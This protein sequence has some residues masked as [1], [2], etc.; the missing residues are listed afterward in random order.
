MVI[1]PRQKAAPEQQMIAKA[2][3]PAS[4]EGSP[5]PAGSAVRHLPTITLWHAGLPCHPSGPLLS[6]PA[7]SRPEAASDPRPQLSPQPTFQQLFSD[8]ATGGFSARLSFQVCGWRGGLIE[9]ALLEFA[10]P[11]P[12]I[13]TG[14]TGSTAGLQATP[15]TRLPPPGDATVGRRT[16][17]A[18][19]R[20]AR[21]S[22]GSYPQ[23]FPEFGALHVCSVENSW[24]LSTRFPRVPWTPPTRSDVVGASRPTPCRRAASKRLFTGPSPAQE[25]FRA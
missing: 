6:L 12:V 24:S 8:S 23:G 3:S 2:A 9:L 7:G 20:G 18:S 14:S 25:R 4:G 21:R 19:S 11:R 15:R 10:L 22:G 5:G 16:R 13:H 1:G 17:Q